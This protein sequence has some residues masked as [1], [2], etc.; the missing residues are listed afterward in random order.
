[1]K[2]KIYIVDY[3]FVILRGVLIFKRIGVVGIKG[4][5]S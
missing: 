4:D 1:M 5:K 2:L 3:F